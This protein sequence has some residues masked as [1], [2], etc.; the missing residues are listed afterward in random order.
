MGEWSNL[1]ANQKAL[2]I[3]LAL[4][5]GV[6]SIKDIRDTFNLYSEGG[7][8]HI[9]PSKKGTFTAAAKKHGKSVQEFARQVLAN[10]DNYSPAM[11]KKANF[12]RNASH[13]HTTGGPLYPFSF[14]STVPEVRYA[15]G[16][17]LFWEGGGIFSKLFAPTYE[18]DFNTAFAAARAD[19]KPY[20]KWNG[21]RY[22][23]QWETE[24]YREDHPEEYVPE[25]AFSDAAARIAREEN[26]KNAKDSG[27]IKE[28]NA[29]APHRSVEGGSKTVA[30]GFKLDKHNQAVID[31]LNK[32]KSKKYPEGYISDEFAINH[33]NTLLR[34]DYAPAAKKAYDGKFGEG[35]WEKLSP[36][37]QSLLLDYQYNV[38]GGLE[39]FPN[40]MQGFHDNDYEKIAANYKRYTGGSPLGRNA[41]IAKEL[42]QIFDGYYSIYR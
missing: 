21:E 9:D 22:S 13:W 25:F 11:V 16:G 18:G 26:N 30:Y 35:E 32:N 2:V 36:K 39:S 15:N 34:S 10:K 28:L 42:Q 37:A 4:D 29:W 27:Y 5:N 38:K 7:K 17:H 8:I 12:A 20:F 41:S 31:E 3:K 33:I 14:N 24:K 23:T 40:L 1:T 6:S 19:G